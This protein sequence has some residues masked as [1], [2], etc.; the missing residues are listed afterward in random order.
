[1]RFKGL[2]RRF[3]CVTS[4][5]ELNEGSVWE[6]AL[7][8]A[9]H[10]LSDVVWV[11]DRNRVQAIGRTEDVM[12]LEPLDAKLRSFG[13]HVVVADGHD[14]VS[15]LTARDECD[16]LVQERAGPVVIIANTVKGNGVSFMHD[17]V[18]CH[19]QPMNDAQYDQ[20]LSELTQAHASHL[21]RYGNEN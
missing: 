5:G 12:A 20:A 1:V 17:T 14:F 6:A 15:L 16:R 10:R 3:F 13:F 18:D 8:I 7:F 4:D 9:Q 19:Y 21:S 11:I 2:S